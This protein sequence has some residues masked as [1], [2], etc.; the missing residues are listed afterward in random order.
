MT[1]RSVYRDR[2]SSWRR[3]PVV[4]LIVTS[5]FL[6]VQ[7]SIPLSQLSSDF[8]NRFGWQMFSTTRPVPEF[9]VETSHERVEIS[10]NDYMARVRADI[11]IAEELPPHL[12]QVVPGAQSVTWDDGEYRC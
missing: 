10:L 8:A 7:L 2:V 5:V 1:S 3:S 4:A 11:D 6:V 9:V 12:C